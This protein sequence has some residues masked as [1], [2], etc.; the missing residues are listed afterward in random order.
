MTEMSMTITKKYLTAVLLVI[1]KSL[2]VDATEHASLQNHARWGFWAHKQIHRQAVYLM[3]TP[4]ADFFRA[5]VLDLVEHSVDPDN[6]RRIDPNEGATH[7]IDLD[8]YGQPPFPALPRTY[9]DAVKKFGADSVKNNGTVPWRIAA[10]ADSL[11]EAFKARDKRKILFF[12]ANVGHYVADC[13]VPLH[14]TENYDGQLTNQKGIHARWESVVPEKFMTPFETSYAAANAGVYYI[15]DRVAESFKWSL[16]SFELCREVLAAD[17]NAVQ[18]VPPD[19][20]IIKTKSENGKER[21]EYSAA[22][23]AC[24]KKELGNMVEARFNQSVQRVAAV[25]YS[26]WIDAGQPDLTTLN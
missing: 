20:L 4:M 25:W 18:S 9:T 1:L 21:D 24:Y 12:A 2:P 19:K 11:K 14:A 15:A 16:E 3:P 7:Y 26:A 6:R 10:F 8:R 23:Y 5:N 13:N 22:Y 17:K